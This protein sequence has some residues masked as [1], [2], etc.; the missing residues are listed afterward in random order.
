MAICLPHLGLSK[1]STSSTDTDSFKPLKF[2]NV[3]F[4]LKVLGNSSKFMSMYHSFRVKQIIS[5]KCSE[6]DAVENI[7]SVT[8]VP[9][10]ESAN[11]TDSGSGGDNGNGRFPA[12]GGGGGGGGEDDDDADDNDEKEFGPIMKFEEVMREAE[13]RGATL[14]S[15]MLE[16]AKTI[17]LRRLIVTRYLDLQVSVIGI[18]N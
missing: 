13:M 16:A 6:S 14:P 1:L 3:N 10:T 18:L 17:G 4:E 11:K 15:D 5:I 7:I 9:N 8:E 2:Q 12:G